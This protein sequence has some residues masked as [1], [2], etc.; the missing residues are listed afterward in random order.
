M[1]AWIARGIEA[2]QAGRFQEACEH[3]EKAVAFNPG[4]AQAHLAL[5]AARLTLY[6]QRP[7]GHSLHPASDGHTMER[8]WAAFQDKEKAILSEQNSTNWPLAEQSLQRANQLDPEDPLII[9]YL[10]SLYFAWKDPLDEANDRFDEAKHWLER[11][12]EV[13]PDHKDAD[14]QCGLILRAKAGKLVPNYGRYP[15][16]PE[17]DLA[18]L[19]SQ[20]EPLLDEASRHLERASALYGDRTAA[21]FLMREVS[22]MR[23]YLADPI[24]AAEALRREHEEM[25]RRHMLGSVG[26]NQPAE[27]LGSP[28]SS[29]TITFQLSPEALA[30]D[31]ARPFPP[32]P[33]RLPVV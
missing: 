32:N 30:E 12:L 26:Q 28:G 2:Y 6:R 23:A 31:R 3:F 22:G 13:R 1:E 4:S 25:F 19:R 21:P 24:R 16:P 17:P 27:D 7:A 15:A 11:L 10:C 8:A 14:V 9:E 20:V 29:A 18:S 5:G 33:W